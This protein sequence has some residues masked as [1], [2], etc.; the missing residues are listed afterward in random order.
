MLSVTAH[1]ALGAEM[2]QSTKLNK[3]YGIK[4]GGR[5]TPK[6]QNVLHEKQNRCVFMPK[7]L[8]WRLGTKQ[9]VRCAMKCRWDAWFVNHVKYVEK[10][11]HKR[12]T[13]TIP[14]L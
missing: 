12:I 14:N 7:T 1:T 13:T 2:I 11:C 8:C 9:G 10:F 6:R 5:K 3:P 4:H